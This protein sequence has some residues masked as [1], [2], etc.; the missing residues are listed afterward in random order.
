[1]EDNLSAVSSSTLSNCM[2]NGPAQKQPDL[3]WTPKVSAKIRLTK[4]CCMTSLS[5]IT[6]IVMTLARL[7]KSWLPYTTIDVGIFSFMKASFCSLI[8][9]INNS[10]FYFS[11]SWIKLYPMSF[12]KSSNDKAAL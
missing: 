6:F 8:N 5:Q 7:L 4:L 10:V 12:F 1:M 9:F 11:L 2:P 3:N